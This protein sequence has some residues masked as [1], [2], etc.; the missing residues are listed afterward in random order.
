MATYRSARSTTAPAVRIVG[1][2][3]VLPVIGALGA[4]CGSERGPHAADSAS[5]PPEEFGLSVAELDRRIEST[6]QLIATCMRDQGFAYVAIDAGTIKKAMGSDKSAPGM[7]AEEYLS[8][9]GL[10]I[11]TQ[12]DK[13]LVVFGAGATN[14]AYLDGLPPADQ[15]AFK[16]ALWGESP[17][18]N[19][20][21]ALEEE[22][23]S[24]TGGC[25]RTAAESAYTTKE[26]TGSYINPADRR[27]AQD[28]RMIRA[29]TKWS[30][31]MRSDA[32][33]YATP[34]DVDADLAERLDAI[35]N[36]QDPQ[37]LTGSALDE[38]HSLQ[39]EERA[40]AAALTSC[41]ERFLE[42]VQASI[43]AEVYGSTS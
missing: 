25:T 24:T 41:E 14:T 17:D 13:P 7:S 15:V 38:L 28:P 9:Y 37:T 5:G 16:R 33:E 19:H 4:A 36:G 6:E 30:D 12:S 34:D 8:R 20:A 32:F 21:R 29:L 43:E 22:D 42:P 3:L 18:M 10:G 26:L 39:D 35:T 2:F 11:T 27:I 31:C 23:F 1:L 40:V